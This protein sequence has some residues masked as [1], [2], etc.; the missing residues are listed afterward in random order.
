MCLDALDDKK[1]KNLKKRKIKIIKV[2]KIGYKAVDAHDKLMGFV[3]G[4]KRYFFG[5]ECWTLDLNDNL[6]DT[7]LWGLKDKPTFYPSGF[8]CYVKLKDAINLVGLYGGNI[9]RPVI[10]EFEVDVSDVVAYG[11]EEEEEVIVSK[12]VRFTGNII[13]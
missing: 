10:G 11:N 1:L 3:S 4:V 7:T 12:C 9:T 6:L 8:H 2:Y 5:K 13:S